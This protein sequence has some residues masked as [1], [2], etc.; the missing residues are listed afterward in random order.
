[1]EREPPITHADVQ[2]IMQSLFDIRVGVDYLVEVVRGE[3][4]DDGE[5]GE[6]EED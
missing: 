5:S 3:D 2:A 6:E 1:V 4:E